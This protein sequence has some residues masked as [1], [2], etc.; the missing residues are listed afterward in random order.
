MTDGTNVK[1]AAL[2]AEAQHWKER[3]E[4]ERERLAKLWVAY[5]A[6]EAEL[7]AK[8]PATKDS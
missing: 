1:D 4:A 3:Y 5:K 8:D 6:L 7:A 2:A